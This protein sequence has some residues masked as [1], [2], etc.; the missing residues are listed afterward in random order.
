MNRYPGKLT[1]HDSLMESL[2]HRFFFDSHGAGS[3]DSESPKVAK[4]ADPE[5]GGRHYVF[6]EPDKSCQAPKM[7]ISIEI[8]H[9]RVA[10]G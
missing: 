8:M 7:H 4:F 9:I 2:A 6:P 3:F 1:I 10:Y 5:P